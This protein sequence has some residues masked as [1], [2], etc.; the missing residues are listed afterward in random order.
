[1]HFISDGNE[2]ANY[3]KEY[4]C[5]DIHFPNSSSIMKQLYSHKHTPSNPHSPL[6]HLPLLCP[7]RAHHLIAIQQTQRI[8]RALELP[9]RINGIF[10]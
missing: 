10:P 5:F 3:I 4:K 6:P 8:K 9:H 1:M 7:P 2:Q